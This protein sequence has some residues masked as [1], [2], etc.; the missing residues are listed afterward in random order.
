MIDAGWG[1]IV[2]ISSSS[3]QSGAPYMAHYS[4]SKGGVIGLTK[5]LARELAGAGITVNTIPP[6]LVD[7]PMAR[8][9]EARGLVNVDTMAA[10][11]PLGRAGTPDD[12]AARVRVPVFRRRQ[13]RHRAGH[14]RQRRHVHL[15]AR[16]RRN[17]PQQL[18]GR[19]HDSRFR[20]GRLLLRPVVAGGPVPVLRV[21]AR[22]VPGHPAPA[23]RGG[24]GLGLGRGGRRVPRP[25][26]VLVV[27]LGDRPVRDASR[28]RSRATTSA[29]S[30]SAT[31]ISSR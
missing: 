16:T 15:D 13:L 31:A 2:T 22:A 4:A 10:M 8:D 28:C 1:R 23:P 27:Q 12:I 24:R 5:A 30:S 21:P 29:R 9:A 18:A 19:P 17:A 14:R 7:T 6:S 25:R 3:A 20:T 11:V 26:H